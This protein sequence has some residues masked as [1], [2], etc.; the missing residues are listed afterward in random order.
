MP[1]PIIQYTDTAAERGVLSEYF[2]LPSHT[3]PASSAS[4]SPPTAPA[5]PPEPPLP[6]QPPHET[7]TALRPGQAYAIYN[8]QDVLGALPADLERV[9]RRAARWAGVEE[10]YV[11]GVVERYERRLVR[12]WAGVRKRER[13]EGAAA[14]AGEDEEEE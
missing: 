11:C 5:A 10:E 8:T 3:T 9:V 2:P 4:P 12:W 6:A 7:S 1:H 13:E 14:A